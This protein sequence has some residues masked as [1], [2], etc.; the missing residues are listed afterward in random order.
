LIYVLFKKTLYSN[1][2]KTYI[3]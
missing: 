3:R 1:E 2:I